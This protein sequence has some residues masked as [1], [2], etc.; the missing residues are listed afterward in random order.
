VYYIGEN[1]N[2]FVQL[3]KIQGFNAE[4]V[5]LLMQTYRTYISR[6]QAEITDIM[7]IGYNSVR[8]LL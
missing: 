5:I 4:L 3:S 7:P 2:Y 6:Q 8:S 1:I